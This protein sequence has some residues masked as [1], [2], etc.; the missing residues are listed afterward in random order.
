MILVKIEVATVQIQSFSLLVV[1]RS[2]FQKRSH[3][4]AAGIWIRA[5]V[6]IMDSRAI[7]R[8]DIGSNIRVV[9]WALANLSLTYAGGFHKQRAPIET[10]TSLLW[11]FGK[12]PLSFGNPKI[13]QHPPTALEGTPN[14]I[15]WRP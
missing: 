14:T 4:E 9:L 11:L 2:C 1:R 7:L 10:S 8:M 5:S 15:K 13:S 12:G 6:N 3:R